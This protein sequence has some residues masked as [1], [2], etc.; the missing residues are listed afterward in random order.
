MEMCYFQELLPTEN[1]HF[2]EQ[3]ETQGIKLNSSW[4]ENGLILL[5]FSRLD[6]QSCKL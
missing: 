2:L 1:V 4:K 5:S 6:Y 3:C